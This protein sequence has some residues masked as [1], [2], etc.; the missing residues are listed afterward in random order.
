M[1]I[2]DWSS[3][4]CSSDLAALDR[5]DLRVLAIVQFE[6]PVEERVKLGFDRRLP[7]DISA[8][9]EDPCDRRR[10][11][12]QRDQQQAAPGVNWPPPS[13]DEGASA[14]GATK[15]ATDAGLTGRSEERRVGNG[16]VRR[17]RTRW[18]PDP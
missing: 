14:G 15:G 8:S 9:D 6:L 10:E 11:G 16:W 13:K 5:L 17:W 18:S 12:D 2:S 1:R 3:D 4:V 7:R